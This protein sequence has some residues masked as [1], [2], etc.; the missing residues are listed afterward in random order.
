MQEY[1]AAA[2]ERQAEIL[3][4]TLNVVAIFYL[5]CAHVDEF[6]E[7]LQKRALKEN[8][9]DDANID[10]IRNRLE[11]YERESKPVLEYYGEK[12]LHP[13]NADQKPAKVLFDILRDVVER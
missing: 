2:P 1:R 10:V 8:R 5:R 3:K 13:I 11:T 12:V 6:T 4:E 7:R 9:L